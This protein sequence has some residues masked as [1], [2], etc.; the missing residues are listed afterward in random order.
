MCYSGISNGG[1]MK[2]DEIDLILHTCKKGREKIEKTMLNLFGFPTM[3]T[4]VKTAVQIERRLR[5]QNEIAEKEFLSTEN[6]ANSLALFAKWSTM[7]GMIDIWTK[8][9]SIQTITVPRAHENT[10]NISITLGEVTK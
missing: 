3:L 5:I 1:I 4:A 2:S 10:G 9:I 6:C 8:Y 7:Q